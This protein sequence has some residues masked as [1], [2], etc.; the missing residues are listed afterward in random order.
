M[1]LTS[2]TSTTWGGWWIASSSSPAFHWLRFGGTRSPERR[3]A[4]GAAARRPMWRA[5]PRPLTPARYVARRTS[6]LGVLIFFE[7]K[8]YKTHVPFC[9]TT[10]HPVF[11]SNPPAFS[12][13]IRTCGSRRVPRKRP[14][15]SP[16]ALLARGTTSSLGPMAPR[17]PTKVPRR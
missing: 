3:P 4:R 13:K 5:A 16:L 11:R 7:Y 10:S 12:L 15:S 8:Q 9:S 6:G 2:Q 1:S 17:Q 14:V